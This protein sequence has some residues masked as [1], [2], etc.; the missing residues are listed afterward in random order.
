[1][2]EG[3]GKP[4]AGGGWQKL[5]ARHSGDACRQLQA[6]VILCS[7]SLTKRHSL[8][9][10]P[11]IR[12][13]FSTPVSLPKAEQLSFNRRASDPHRSSSLFHASPTIKWHKIVFVEPG[14]LVSS[15]HALLLSEREA[16]CRPPDSSSLALSPSTTLLTVFYLHRLLAIPSHIVFHGASS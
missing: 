13:F 1:M 11:R 5:S 4:K 8:Q 15:I 7:R 6:C 16:H 9:V 14:L 12:A 3:N 2:S 10:P